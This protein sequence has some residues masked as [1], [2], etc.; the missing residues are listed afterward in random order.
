[1]WQQ[2]PDGRVSHPFEPLL[3]ALTLLVIPVVIV[4]ES[5]A[6]HSVGAVAGFIAWFL[7]VL[8]QPFPDNMWWVMIACALIGG[9]LAISFLLRWPWQHDGHDG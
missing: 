3:L 7:W 8:P 5:S 2:E 6:P 1:M 9:L 4:E